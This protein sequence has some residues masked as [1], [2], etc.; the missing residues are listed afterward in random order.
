MTQ[1]SQPDRPRHRVLADVARQLDRRRDGEL[2]WSRQTAAVFADHEDLLVALH[3]RWH[4][5]LAVR[6][7]PLLERGCSPAELVAVW[8]ALAAETTGQRQVLDR[9]SEADLPRL[10][11]VSQR[12]DAALAV[13]AGLVSHRVDPRIA[14]RAWRVAVT[15]STVQEQRRSMRS[16]L[17]V[18][19][20]RQ[21]L[22][23]RCP[24]R[25]RQ[26]AA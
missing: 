16:M 23:S 3:A 12:Q 25:T 11:A 21:R 13:V 7:D 2:P 20:L 24:C 9:A 10:R 4:R 1:Q 5:I 18:P 22:L 17:T 14:A 26:V 19:T 8:R 6:I 15:A